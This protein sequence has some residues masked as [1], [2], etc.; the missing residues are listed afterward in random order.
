ML[1]EK[2]KN[3]VIDF[4]FD[5]LRHTMFGDG[6]E[7]DYLRDGVEFK[8]LNNYSDQELIDEM[9]TFTGEEEELVVRA[10]QEL[11]VE[12]MLKT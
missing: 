11:A 2:T 7:D 5:N 4:L 6:L 1:S 9:L 3:E 8:G 12:H 10:K